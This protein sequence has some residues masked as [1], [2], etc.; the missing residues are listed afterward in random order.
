MSV[1]TASHSLAISQVGGEIF[2]EAPPFLPE[3]PLN[4]RNCKGMGRSPDRHS[5]RRPQFRRR[6][7]HDLAA[8][9]EQRHMLEYVKPEM[10]SPHL[11][12]QGRQKRKRPALAREQ[13]LWLQVQA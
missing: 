9:D 2:F 13:A 6:R 10:T 4:L 7:K 11:A 1:R 12:E 5:E 3:G 8:P